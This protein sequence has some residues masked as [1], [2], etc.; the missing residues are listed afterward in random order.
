MVYDINDHIAT[1]DGAKLESNITF[2]HFRVCK[3]LVS[4]NPLQA[5]VEKELSKDDTDSDGLTEE[6]RQAF[7]DD[8]KC[9]KCRKAFKAKAGLTRHINQNTCEKYVEPVA[10]P[11]T[12]PIPPL[13]AQM[14]AVDA[15][16]PDVIVY[17]TCPHCKRNFKNAGSL[18]T[19]LNKCKMA[20]AATTSL[21]K[22]ESQKD[23]M[24]KFLQ[25]APD[26]KKKYLDRMGGHPEYMPQWNDI[27]YDADHGLA[28]CPKRGISFELIRYFG[29][30]DLYKEEFATGTIP[31]HTINVPIYIENF[32]NIIIDQT[33]LPYRKIS[34][35]ARKR[36]YPKTSSF[37]DS[38]LCSCCFTPLYEDIY[39][40]IYGTQIEGYAVCGVCMHFDPDAH[41][42]PGKTILRVSYPVSMSAIIDRTDFLELK[43]RIMK[44]TTN[45]VSYASETG[46]AF[47]IGDKVEYIGWTGFLSDFIV[48]NNINKEVSQSAECAKI[49]PAKLIRD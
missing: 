44:Q 26:E 42:K 34:T 3:N 17:K 4:F 18:K 45:I 5:I 16:Q 2:Q 29:N 8:K 33:L 35:V 32:Q 28:L 6:E 14:N 22:V 38:E 31:I 49:F 21:A 11:A 39:V 19:H 36:Q 41:C 20:T 13:L 37:T 12:M 30:W 40:V 23:N 24:E 25:M 46:V 15:M 27:A 48:Y 1:A 9:P 10:A 43:K 7:I 47:L